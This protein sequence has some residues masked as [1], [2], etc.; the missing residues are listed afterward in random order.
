MKKDIQFFVLFFTIITYLLNSNT[1]ADDT[2]KQNQHTIFMAAP[3]E[4]SELPDVILKHV[5]QQETVLAVFPTSEK[6][7]QGTDTLSVDLAGE[8]TQSNEVVEIDEVSANPK[9]AVANLLTPDRMNATKEALAD[10][11]AA[12]ESPPFI[13]IVSNDVR[14]IPPEQQY[15]AGGGGVCCGKNEDYPPGGGGTCCGDTVKKSHKAIFANEYFEY[16]QSIVKSFHSDTEGYYV[17]DLP[18]FSLPTEDSHELKVV[19]VGAK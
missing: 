3:V 8:K 9:T 15:P 5:G 4:H 17:V 10:H 13:L 1:F 19:K 12:R 2:K 6:N 14:L 16:R 18:E 11:N 7:F